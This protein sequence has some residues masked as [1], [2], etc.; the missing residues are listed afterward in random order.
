MTISRFARYISSKVH[1]HGCTFFM[2]GIER[3][4]MLFCTQ[5]EKLENRMNAGGNKYAQFIGVYE[6]GT[7]SHALRHIYCVERA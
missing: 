4:E 1:P 6:L 3:S 5:F 7:K 2:R